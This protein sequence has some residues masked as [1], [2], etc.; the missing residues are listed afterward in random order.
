MAQRHDVIVIGSSSGGIPVLMELAAQLPADFPACILVVQHIGAQPSELAHLLQ[1]R[2][3]MEVKF[4][5]SG[6]PL[7]PGVMYVAPPDRH[8]LVE[9]GV[10]CLTHDPKENYT[11]PAIDPLF[12][13]AAIAH[14]PAVIGVVLSGLLDDGTAGLQAIKACGGV[15]VVQDPEDA[16]EPSMPHSARD[17]VS[18]DVVV[19]GAELAQAL[20]ALVGVSTIASS[21]TPERLLQE[22]RLTRGEVEMPMETLDQLGRPSKISCPEC[23]GVLWELADTQPQRYRCHT[24]H[25]YTLRA[26]DQAQVARM[27]EAIWTAL[28]ALQEREMLLRSVVEAHRRQ[29]VSEEVARVENEAAH[30]ARHAVQL[31]RLIAG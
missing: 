22:H 12:R 27:D 11:R 4:A 15:A 10:L 28:R 6:L 1:R 13:S 17:N 21:N 14:G 8:L 20:Q 19:P 31:Q 3:A 25:G 26:L 7:R 30:L 18:V 5:E 24:G 9:D 16:Q 2:S 29:G 23:G